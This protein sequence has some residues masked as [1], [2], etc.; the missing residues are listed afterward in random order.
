[1][2]NAPPPNYPVLQ[3]P[4][5]PL[6][7][8]QDDWLCYWGE[9]LERDHNGQVILVHPLLNLGVERLSEDNR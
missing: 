2:P 5:S 1:M 8:Y 7:E 3:A 6:P 9:T 4:F